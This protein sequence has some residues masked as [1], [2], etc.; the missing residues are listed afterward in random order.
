MSRLLPI[1]LVS[2]LLLLLGVAPS[3]VRANAA[4]RKYGDPEFECVSAKQ[5]AAAKY[6]ADA[7]KAWAQWAKKQDDGERDASLAEAGA[8]LQ[9][10]FDEADARSADKGVDCVEQTVS[11]AELEA[12]MAAAVLDVVTAI[13]AGLDFGDHRDGKCAENLLKAAGERSRKFLAAESHHTKKAPD[14]GEADKREAIQAIAADKFS[15][16]WS[17]ADCPTAA[18]E[19]DV[20]SQLDALRDE[21]VF[22]TSVSP[23]LD[24]SEFQPV[25]PVGPIQYEGRELNPR[26]GFDADP[27]YHFFVKR[28][29]VNKLVMYYQGG[30][31]CWENLTCSIPVCKNGAD[32]V[33]DDPDNAT[34]GFADLSNPD[35]PFK[36]WNIV[37]VTYCTCDIHFGDADQ[38]YSG[39]FPDINV[40]HR[41]FENAKVVEK[42]ARENFLNPDAVFVTGS[43]AGGYGALFRATA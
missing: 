34:A 39:L 24:D 32:P 28:G 27:D 31:A 42:F 1:S 10:A 21:V 19:G 13:E 26:C 4:L 17:R 29:S 36:D 11:G 35:N 3:E 25:S 16:A 40:S 12:R 38:T 30:G 37:F 6:S 15:D 23:M 8:L 14:G 5:K 22:H 41:G 7:F 9:E 20:A 33:T 43:S 2:S 18:S